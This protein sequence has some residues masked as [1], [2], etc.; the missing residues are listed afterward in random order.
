M[1]L[2]NSPYHE[3]QDVT[4]AKGIALGGIHNLRNIFVWE[5]VVSNFLG[6]A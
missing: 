3:C 6:K 2:T 5:K 4:W 1:G